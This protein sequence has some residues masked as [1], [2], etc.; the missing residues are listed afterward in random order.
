M[1][2]RWEGYSFVNQEQKFDDKKKSKYIDLTSQIDVIDEW[3]E[4]KTIKSG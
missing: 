3:A 2:R 1:Q 4:L